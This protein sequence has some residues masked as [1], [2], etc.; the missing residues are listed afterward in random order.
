[1]SYTPKTLFGG[2]YAYDKSV[3][4][5]I[6]T[7][8]V[9]HAFGL[10]TAGD[11]VAGNL[12]GVTFNAGRIVD[13]NIANE[14][15]PSGA[16]LQI[17]CSAAH[18]LTTGDVVTLHGMNNAGHNGTTF[19]TVVDS[20]KFNC[21]NITYV[22]GSGASAGSVYEP[23][24]LQI[25]TGGG[26]HYQAAFVI[27]GTAGGANKNFKWELNVGVTAQDNIVSERTSTATLA[28]VSANGNIEVSD[29]D[30]IWLSGKNTTDTTD[31]TV[32]HFSLHLHRI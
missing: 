31:Y 11:I 26:G 12:N 2:M 27:D 17:E 5:S 3:A 29:G 24:Y 16:I 14:I 19:V 18:N 21:D 1:M 13:S 20:T 25:G 7:Q 32:K 10:R 23:A 15:N 22:A 6:I 30:R 28:S 9:Y 8:S 4:F